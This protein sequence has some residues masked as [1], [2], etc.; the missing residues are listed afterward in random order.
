MS[1]HTTA[2]Q[3]VG[4]YLHIGLTWLITD[5][6]VGPGVTGTPIV[7]EGRVTDGDGK[8]VNDALVEIWQA[9][10]H[11]RYAHPDDKHDAPLEP[12]FKGFGRVPTDEEGRFR[13]TTIKPG[14]VPAPG[15]GLQAPHINVTILMRGL[16]KHLTS[17][18]Y[19]DGDP[20]NAQDPVLQSVPEARRSTLLA[21]T[22]TG[23]GT[24][25]WNVR[26]QGDGETVFFEY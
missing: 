22:A 7:L 3:T 20:T 1:L 18:I 23:G 24:L 14:R 8:P 16:L 13:F 17:R 4:P 5:N 26:L 19:F 12:A 2:S 15:G 10:A 9:N 21:R 25:A 11:G 6:L